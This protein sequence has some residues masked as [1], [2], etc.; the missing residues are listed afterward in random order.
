MKGKAIIQLFDKNGK[1][2]YKQEHNNIIT[3]AYQKL[4]NPNFPR[5][6]VGVYNF[7]LSTLTP[8]YRKIFGGIMLF[9]DNIDAN[10]DNFMITKKQY[11]DFV[12]N[13]GSAYSGNSVYRGSFNETESIIDE[14]NKKITMVWDFPSNAANGKIKCIGLCPRFVGDAGLIKDANDTS[15]TSLLCGYGSDFE[16]PTIE[17]EHC[18]H[19][20]QGHNYSTLGYYLYSKDLNTNVYVRVSGKTL[21]FTEVKRHLDL[22]LTDSIQA[23]Q[24]REFLVD[25]VNLYNY[26]EYVYT[27]DNNVSSPLNIDYEL[28]YIY[29]IRVA[30]STDK[31]DLT[32]YKI[33]ADTYELESSNVYTFIITGIQ[34]K[35]LDCRY[36]NNKIYITTNK[37]DLYICD[38][39]DSTFKS[40]VIGDPDYNHT[41]NKFFDTVIIHRTNNRSRTTNPVFILDNNDNLCRNNIM[42]YN[43][44][45]SD[46]NRPINKFFTNDELYN[47]PIGILSKLYGYYDNY[48]EQD[49]IVLP[50][51]SSI[52]N[53][54]EFIK[55]PSN[56]M[57]ITY[58]LSEY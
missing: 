52:N 31:L 1:E 47:Y 6:I 27:S 56:T 26:T 32:L 16:N 46:S 35:T 5:D 28:G 4:F 3:N 30:T 20:F 7:R 48:E 41:V 45:S 14:E 40:L 58:I 44:S 43:Y 37:D 34:S 42:E 23:T 9:S 25:N 57:K 12:G 15:S 29:Y 24:A 2:V 54:D 18:T 53:V 51:L 11:Y 17:S 22:S 10:A 36:I 50:H 13:A 8:I 33:N 21:Y 55:Y 49:Q 39:T 38:I 19:V